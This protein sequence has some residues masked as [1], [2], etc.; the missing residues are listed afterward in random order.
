MTKELTALIILDGFGCRA[1]TKGNAIAADGAK[2]IMALAA[3]YP[4]TQIAA[5]GRTWACR[6]GKW[7]TARWAT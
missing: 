5:S 1:E 2:N 4:H 6:M 7:A 3:A